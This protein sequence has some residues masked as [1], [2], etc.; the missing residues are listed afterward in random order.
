[1]DAR[2]K[3][4]LYGL[5]AKTYMGEELDPLE[6]NLDKLI[7]GAIENWFEPGN[8][9][10]LAGVQFLQAAR[11]ERDL[12]LVTEFL[13]DGQKD[14]WMREQFRRRVWRG[15]DPTWADLAAE[16]ELEHQ[17]GY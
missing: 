4:L 11:E 16:W 13:R 1:M 10:M 3:N 7:Q 17:K 14:A 5:V 15:D 8:S 2:T 12:S 9:L 6:A